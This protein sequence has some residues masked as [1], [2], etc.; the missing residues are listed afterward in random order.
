MTSWLAETFAS[1]L[2]E[3]L[4]MMSGEKPVLKCSAGEAP[5]PG[6]RQ[7][8]QP[9]AVDGGLGWLAGSDAAWTGIG[10]ALLR[11]A[12][13]EEE[14]PATAGSTFLETVVQAFSALAA[15]IGRRLGREVAAAKGKETTESSSDAV[16]TAADVD[17]PWYRIDGGLGETPDAPLF[18]RFSAAL[19]ELSN[20]QPA[21]PALTEITPEAAPRALSP[22]IEN[23]RTLE[24]LLDVELPVSVSFGRAQLQLKDVIKLTTG[25]IVELNRAVTEPVEVIVNNCVIARGEVVVVEGNFGVRIQQVISK[26]ERLRTLY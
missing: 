14:D 24:L 16:P 22:S 18:V 2:A 25:S 10:A 26:Q 20:P 11:A 8:E 4:E 9:F 3:S 15:E 5:P 21:K 6:L 17:C 12:G 23:S 7:W 19:S 1:K 13:I